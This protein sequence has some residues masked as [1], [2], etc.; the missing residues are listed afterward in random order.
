Y[1]GK[2]VIGRCRPQQIG[3]KLCRMLEVL[4]FNRQ[5][6][7]QLG[8]VHNLPPL[9]VPQRSG[10]R[11]HRFAFLV[12]PD[13][14]PFALFRRNLNPRHPPPPPPPPFRPLPPPAPL[15]P[16]STPPP[17]CSSRPISARTL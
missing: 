4:R 12:R 11:F 15:S 9:L 7:N 10:Q 17:T 3:I 8:V 13:R 16:G 5:Q 14:P 6:L 2:I 1:V